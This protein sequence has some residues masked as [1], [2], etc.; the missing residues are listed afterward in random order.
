MAIGDKTCEIKD[1]LSD[2]FGFGLNNIN[3]HLSW[4]KYEGLK[5][6]EALAYQVSQSSN[7]I[8]KNIDGNFRHTNEKLC[9]FEH[10]VDKQFCKVEQ[11]INANIDGNF[12]F[13]NDKLY[14][15]K[16]EALKNKEALSQQV[17]YTH[18]ATVSEMNKSTT[19][20]EKALVAGFTCVSQQLNDAK[21]EA[22]KNKEK[23]YAQA[24]QNFAQS[25]MDAYK[26]KCDLQM[27]MQ[28]IKFDACKNKDALSRELEECCCELKMQSAK[29][30]S[31]LGQ[32]VDMRAMEASALARDIDTTRIRDALEDTKT[33]NT[34]LKF[35]G[36]DDDYGYGY[37]RRGRRGFVNYNHNEIFDDHRR[38]HKH[39][40][41]RS[42]S[43]DS[44][45]SE[46]RSRGSRSSR[47]S[48]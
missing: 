45:D 6:K 27:Q 26:N 13:T 40:R 22:L 1:K 28:E 43:S 48:R 31:D 33:E 4:A 35:A 41:S 7:C 20:I 39:H 19:C 30:A 10:N 34:V 3:E 38:R 46:S 37:G 18:N 8:E 36:A 16:Y 11:N 9:N 47:G 21:Y 25:Q 2:K 14:D 12:R 44:S 32:K 24:A 5:N 29:Q 23:L 15:A 17:G 42:R